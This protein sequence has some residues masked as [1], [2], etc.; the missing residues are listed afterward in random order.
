M[1][2]KHREELLKK[3]IGEENF[4]LLLEEVS[5]NWDYLNSEINHIHQQR[6][7]NSITSKQAEVL[8]KSLFKELEMFYKKTFPKLICDL[9]VDLS[10]LDTEQI[11]HEFCNDLFICFNK[12]YIEK[13]RK[14]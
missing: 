13:F 7:D 12:T 2:D 10:F 14:K 5:R 6:E 8:V 9:K 4:Q 1:D 11:C 3:Y